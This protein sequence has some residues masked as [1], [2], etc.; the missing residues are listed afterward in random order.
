MGISAG[1]I[2]CIHH[3]TITTTSGTLLDPS[4]SYTPPRP[5]SCAAFSATLSSSLS[6]RLLDPPP[7]PRSSPFFL[8]RASSLLRSLFLVRKSSFHSLRIHFLCS[9]VLCPPSRLFGPSAPFPTGVS[10]HLITLKLESSSAAQ[11]RASTQGL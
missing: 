5:S 11:R 3:V 8:G 10:A 9:Q 4:A 1:S 7:P 2:V 6:L